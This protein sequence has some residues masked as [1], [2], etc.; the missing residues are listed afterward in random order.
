[1]NK[2]A[3]KVNQEMDMEPKIASGAASDASHK[4]A[5][6]ATP[7]ATSSAALENEGTGAGSI[8]TTPENAGAGS[9]DATP[10]K[11]EAA[12]DDTLKFSI[13][14]LNDYLDAGKQPPRPE[15]DNDP[16]AASMLSLL[17]RLRELT[18]VMREEESQPLDKEAWWSRIT[19]VLTDEMR[20][21]R[22][23]A[24]SKPQADGST[25]VSEGEL[26]AFIRGIGDARECVVT[27]VKVAG[28]F[29]TPGA[30]LTLTL[31]LTVPVG[32]IPDNAEQLRQAVYREVS[33]QYALNIAETNVTVAD[34][35]QL[36]QE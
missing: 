35:L 16:Q 19:V 8:G 3:E 15:I 27:K 1:M 23:I 4:G 22:Q 5:P 20:A 11:A 33:E 2:G 31:R 14:E 25:T 12:A 10:A 26:K 29:D 6:I 30:P 9:I 7:E 17:E 18:A 32:R 21:G 36:V 28:D 13:E 24:L 34:I